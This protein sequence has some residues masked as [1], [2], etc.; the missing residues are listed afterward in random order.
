MTDSVQLRDVAESDFLLLFEQQLDPEANRIANVPARDWEG[1][2][3][4]RAR[5]V[6]DETVVKKTI[7]CKGQVAGQ[8]LSFKRFGQREVGY[9]LG[10]EYWGKGIASRA[11][12]AFM[13]ADPERPLFARVAKPNGASRRVLE[14]CGFV[15]HGE[16]FW[17]P[18][19]G[20]EPSEDFILKLY[21][22]TS[23][24]SS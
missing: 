5:L 3:T 12:A 9:W 19:A 11:L 15:L 17:F 10:R 23:G 13:H 2:Q 1:F 4:H 8:I 21:A 18:E 22:E 7:L 14:K 6:G 20:G 16:E 24:E